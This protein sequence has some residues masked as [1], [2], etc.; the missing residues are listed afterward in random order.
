MRAV[1]QSTFERPNTTFS[2]KSGENSLPRFFPSPLNFLVRKESRI[3]RQR[4]SRS[5][6]NAGGFEAEEEREKGGIERVLV[7]G[8]PT[9]LMA[10][11]SIRRRTVE[12]QKVISSATRQM[13]S[14][15]SSNFSLPLVLP[16]LFPPLYLLSFSSSRD[17]YYPGPLNNATIYFSQ[18]A[19]SLIKRSL[20][21]TRARKLRILRGEGVEAVEGGLLETHAYQPRA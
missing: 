8:D 3:A 7:R 19:R 21:R 9:R 17:P 14:A 1:D 11:I 13:L 18:A 5:G 16:Y 20:R 2:L 12:L 10:G 4:G 6:L 15:G